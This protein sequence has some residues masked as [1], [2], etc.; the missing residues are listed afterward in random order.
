V[1]LGCDETTIGYCE[2]ANFDWFVSHISE[3]SKAKELSLFD[4]LALC[5][6]KER[7]YEQ[8]IDIYSRMQK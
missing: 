8:A 4:Q 1:G 3:A 6:Q 2:E 7:N 5:L